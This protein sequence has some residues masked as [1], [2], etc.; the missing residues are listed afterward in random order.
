MEELATDAA[1]RANAAG[2][3]KQA[4]KELIRDIESEILKMRKSVG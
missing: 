2:K 4:A 3:A 1:E